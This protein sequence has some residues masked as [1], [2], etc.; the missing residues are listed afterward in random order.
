MACRHAALFGLFM[1]SACGSGPVR[2]RATP[3]EA[4]R[5]AEGRLQERGIELDTAVRSPRHLRTIRYCYAPPDREGSDWN[6]SFARPFHAPPSETV[7]GEVAR[8]D[9]ARAQCEFMFRV[10]LTATGAADGTSQL[11]ATTEWWRK[12]QRSC[13]PLGNPLLAVMRCE[14]AYDGAMAPQAI[15]GFINGM[16]TGL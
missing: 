2:T 10:E 15:E 8:Q 11:E 12:A 16:L 14:Y 13:A 3:E 9:A 7:D 1:L 5:Q 6:R 4:L